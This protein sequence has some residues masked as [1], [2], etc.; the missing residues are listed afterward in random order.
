MNGFVHPA[1]LFLYLNDESPLQAV[2]AHNEQVEASLGDIVA[3]M[4]PAVIHDLIGDFMLQKDRC[5]ANPKESTKVQLALFG[6]SVVLESVKARAEEQAEMTDT[7]Y[8]A[9]VT[10]DDNVYT[11]RVMT[12]PPSSEWIVLGGYRAREEADARIAR[13]I[14]EL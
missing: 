5:E 6:L 7:I 1:S 14:K 10:Q 13:S 12:D 11:H 8:W 3:G 2:T 9:C 4:T